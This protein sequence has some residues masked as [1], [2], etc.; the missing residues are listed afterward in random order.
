MV[1][2]NELG[3]LFIGASWFIQVFDMGK[4]EAKLN[5]KFVL[6]YALGIAMVLLDGLVNYS[7]VSNLLN[8]LSLSGALIVYFKL[9]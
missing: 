9:K 4:K 5:K 6:L 3:L 1:G 7:M 8:L 2:I